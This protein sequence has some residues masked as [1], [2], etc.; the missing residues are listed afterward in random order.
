MEVVLPENETRTQSL[1][2]QQTKL[3]TCYMHLGLLL[4]V[5]WN[6]VTDKMERCYR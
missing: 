5:A 6:K 2:N 1:D 3:V 4:H